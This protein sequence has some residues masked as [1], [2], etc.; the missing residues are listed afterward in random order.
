MRMGERK[1]GG[2]GGRWMCGMLMIRMV[3][4]TIRIPFNHVYDDIMQVYA[5]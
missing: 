2:G 4:W 3:E 5:N 1:G